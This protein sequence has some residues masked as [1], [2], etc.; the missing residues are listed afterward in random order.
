MPRPVGRHRGIPLDFPD[1][2]DVGEHCPDSILATV[3]P[4]P[5]LRATDRE[6]A[7]REFRD[8]LRAVGE[9]LG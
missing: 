6:A 4:S 8:D 1:S 3:H 9:A 7:C 2:I 5:V